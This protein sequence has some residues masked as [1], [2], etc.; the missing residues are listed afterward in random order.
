[1][2]QPNNDDN[3]IRF[4]GKPVSANLLVTPQTARRV[5]AK[6]TRNRPINEHHVQQLIR[7]MESGRWVYNGEAIKW[8]VDDVLLDGQHRLTALSRMPDDFP[9]ITFL[10][11]RG[12]PTSSQDTM[13]QGRKRTAG[14]QLSIDGLVGASSQR[15]IAGAIRVYIEWV[16]G[17]FFGDR[18]R[19][20]ISNPE[21]V[22]W[23]HQHPVEM[24]MLRD[25]AGERLRRIK[26]RP[27]VT[28][29]VMLMLRQVDGEAQRAFCESLITGA[30]L[31][32][33]NPILALRDRLERINQQKVITSDRDLV[34]FFLVAWNAWRDGKSLGKLQ[35]PKSGAWTLDTF[36]EPK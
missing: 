25:I 29:A 5:L 14:D 17:R 34:G 3:V 13:D 15:I 9:G 35:R 6:N 11:V 21:I 27:S 4:F 7:E 23:A 28:V 16:E 20:R 22:E 31:D 19:N 33:G 1:M 30:S 36:P 2:S 24:A 18:V 32:P 12:L 8:S 26:A 10:V